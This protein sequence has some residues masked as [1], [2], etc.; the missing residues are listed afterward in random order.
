MISY[1]GILVELVIQRRPILPISRY[2]LLIV[3]TSSPKGVYCFNTSEKVEFG[4]NALNSRANE[5]ISG[6]LDQQNF[7]SRSYLK[8]LSTSCSAR[9][10]VSLGDAIVGQDQPI[11]YWGVSYGIATG[12]SFVKSRFSALP[13]THVG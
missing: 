5:P 7:D 12:F 8:H 11:H 4:K 3:V 1:P 9:D 6:I 10:L 13:V 2:N